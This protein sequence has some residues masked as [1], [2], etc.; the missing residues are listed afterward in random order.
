MKWYKVC[1]DSA[2]NL[3]SAS[4][5]DP[6]E[7]EREVEEK[8][9][10]LVEAEDVHSAYTLAYKRHLESQRAAQ[11][12]RRAR[13][14]REGKCPYCGR[15]LEPNYMFTRCGVCREGV[16]KSRDRAKNT[17]GTSPPSKKAA[18]AALR[19]ERDAAARYQALHDA[20]EA[21]STK[22]M[23]AFIKWLDDEMK[24]AK[25]KIRA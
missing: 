19:A 21:L 5:I 22:S 3:I 6:S 17:P 15:E 23:D 16:E 25:G 4:L 9:T 2:G 12:E 1:T 7:A 18:H 14:R 11:R 13:Y 20:Q 8:G 10:H 24:K